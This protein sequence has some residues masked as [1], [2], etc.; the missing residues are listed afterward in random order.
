MAQAVTDDLTGLHNRRYLMSHIETLLGNEQGGSIR[1]FAV[2]L[3]DID[4]FK[5]INDTFGHDAGDQVLKEFAQRIARNVRG[6]D[7]AARFGGE[8][9]VVVMPETDMPNAH[10]VAERLRQAFSDAPFAV[11]GV[12]RPIPVTCSI[13]VAVAESREPPDQIIK[14][15]DEALYAAKRD[16]RNRV[17]A[18]AA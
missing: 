15:A 18:A 12:E 17:V 14:R 13:G 6:V 1:S 9:F 8:E 4:H 5:S 7:L 2:M 11:Q 10:V 16:G 3:L